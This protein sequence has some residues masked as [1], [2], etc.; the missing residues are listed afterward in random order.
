MDTRRGLAATVVGVDRPEFTL[1]PD[2]RSR[3]EHVPGRC[4]QRGR[5]LGEWLDNSVTGRG[6]A[7]SLSRLVEDGQRRGRWRITLLLGKW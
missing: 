5:G 7:V 3:G 1:P 2:P 6:D 4:A